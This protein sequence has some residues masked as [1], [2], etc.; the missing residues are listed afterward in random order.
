MVLDQ[1]QHGADPI[2]GFLA[3]VQRSAALAGAIA[4]VHRLA[5]AGKELDILP[6]RLLRTA[7]RPAEDA[8]GAHADEEDAI[9]RGVSLQDRLVHLGSGGERLHGSIVAP[10]N[11][12]PTGG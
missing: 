4:R 11:E 7:P 8:G 10:S 5:N 2:G 6:Q 12:S 1:T 3:V 9:E